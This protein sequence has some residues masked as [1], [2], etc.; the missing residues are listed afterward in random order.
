MELAIENNLHVNLGDTIYYVNVGTK[1]S[2]TDVR[3]DKEGK[4]LSRLIDNDIIENK[5][6]L[7][8]DYNVDRYLAMFNSRIKGLLVV[9]DPDVRKKILISSPS[10][11]IEWLKSE[12]DLCNGKPIR[13][14]DQDTLEELFTPS[15]MEKKLWEK[16]G[17][18]PDF[19]F[20]DNVIFKL[21]GI[22]KEMPV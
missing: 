13:E 19:W 3:L 1:K 7:L 8:G 10:K 16:V 17:Y 15:E 21:P 6:D 9:F 14:K 5:P 2:H 12:L 4:M 11:K 22:T 18:D 20:D